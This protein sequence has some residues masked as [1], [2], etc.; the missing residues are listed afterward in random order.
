MRCKAKSRHVCVLLGHHR[1]FFFEGPEKKD[2]DSFAVATFGTRKKTSPCF[3]VVGE[4]V[5]RLAGKE[6]EN[7]RQTG[8]C[9]SP[10][11]DLQARGALGHRLTCSIQS[12]GLILGLAELRTRKEPSATPVNRLLGRLKGQAERGR[13]GEHD[14]VTLET[15]GNGPDET[16]SDVR[17]PRRVCVPWPVRCLLTPS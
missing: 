11:V 1:I 9:E 10:P 13:S 15:T 5:R 16:V 17:V 12:T 4:F 8:R 6:Q 7:A 2:K 14:V 3:D